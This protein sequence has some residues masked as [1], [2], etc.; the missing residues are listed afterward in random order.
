MP[1]NQNAHRRSRPFAGIKGERTWKEIEP[2]AFVLTKEA[3]WG[4][5]RSPR[6]RAIAWIKGKCTRKEIQPR[7]FVL[8]RRKRRGDTPCWAGLGAG[9]REEEI[10]PRAFA[11][12]RREGAARSGKGP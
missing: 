1:Q 12:D 9:V 8:D 10:Q 5:V 4:R 11:L 3:G 7:A 2:R 6:S